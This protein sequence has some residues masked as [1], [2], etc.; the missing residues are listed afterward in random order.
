M[1]SHE[2]IQSS[3]QHQITVWLSVIHW[4]NR[5]KKFDFGILNLNWNFDCRMRHIASQNRKEGCLVVCQSSWQERQPCQNLPSFGWR[6]DFFL[7]HESVFQRTTVHMA[8]SGIRMCLSQWIL[9]VMTKK[10]SGITNCTCHRNWL[11]CSQTVNHKPMLRS[12]KDKVKG[13]KA[14]C[15]PSHPSSK[16]VLKRAT[17]K[18]EK[19]PDTRRMRTR[20]TCSTR[21]AHTT[22]LLGDSYGGLDY[23]L[24]SKDAEVQLRSLSTCNS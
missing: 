20:A 21:V 10:M 15:G 9:R 1:S 3:R 5:G 16:A 4:W 2:H 17:A 22:P 14:P 11:N 19:E 8:S 23:K 24:A 6:L 7:R 12:S 13:S 18:P